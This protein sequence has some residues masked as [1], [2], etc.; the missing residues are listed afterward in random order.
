MCLSASTFTISF[1][2]LQLFFITFIFFSLCIYIYNFIPLF[3]TFLYHIHIFSL[4]FLS[5]DFLLLFNCHLYLISHIS[6]NYSLLLYFHLW[7]FLC[8]I[9]NFSLR[10]LSINF[11]LLLTLISTF[12]Y[13]IYLYSLY[14]TDFFPL[15]SFLTTNTFSYILPI[16]FLSFL[17]FIFIITRLVVL[18]FIL[19]E[20]DGSG[21][22]DFATLNQAS[23]IRAGSFINLVLIPQFIILNL[24]PHEI[25]PTAANI[26]EIRIL[27]RFF[28]TAKFYLFF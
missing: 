18:P 25:F 6:Y 19:Q 15:Y 3:P 11:L 17:T 13:I 28:F 8:N 7:N 22:A 12:S 20:Q 14:F 5:I 21:W 10:S 4:Y 23:V 16:S 2:S 26:S 27:N 9:H 24:N 1:L